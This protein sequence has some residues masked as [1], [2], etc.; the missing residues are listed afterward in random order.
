MAVYA[1]FHCVTGW[2]RL[3]NLWEGVSAR[4]IA[5]LA[6]VRPEARFVV[7]RDT[8]GFI[9]DLPLADLLAEDVLLATH[10]DGQPLSAE[11]GGPVRLVVPRLYAWKSCKW[12]ERIEFVADNRPGF[13]ESRGYHDRGDPWREERYRR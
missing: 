8:H 10:H 1:G 6:E 7:V 11:H 12:I 3:G 2:S 13:W 5:D 4:T 9:T